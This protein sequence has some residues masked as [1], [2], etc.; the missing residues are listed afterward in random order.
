MTSEISRP[1]CYRWL[2]IA[3]WFCVVGPLFPV[4]AQTVFETKSGHVTFR[5][6]VP[7]HTFTGESDQLVGRINLEESTVDFYV[8]VH[9]LETG[10]ARRDRDMLE[11]LEAEEYPFAE[12]YGT[13]NDSV[14]LNRQEPQP[15]TVTGDFTI[16][17]VTQEITVDGVIEPVEE[18]LRVEA[19]WTVRLEDYNIEPPGILFYRVDQEQDVSIEA[20]LIP[21]EEPS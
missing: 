1:F 8:D 5:S 3:L 13:L 15:V 21:V 17:G 14:D 20:T 18:G 19:E 6:E 9:T 2:G 11:T 10:V 16:H 7:T 4:Q 12:F